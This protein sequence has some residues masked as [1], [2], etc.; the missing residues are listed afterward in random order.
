[1]TFETPTTTNDS[2]KAAN[3]D[4][5]PS[6]IEKKWRQYWEERGVYRVEEDPTKP[7]YYVLDMF[8]YPSGAGLHVG[9]PLGYVASDIFARY[10]RLKGFNVLHP[11]GY[12]A[13]GLPAEQYAIE[14]GIHPETTTRINTQRY[15]Q[16]LDNLGFSYDWSRQ[17]STNDPAYY[18]WT[19]EIFI[20]LYT[21]Y[22]DTAADKARPIADL[23]VAFEKGGN[24]HVQAHTTQEETFS[25]E[26]W[27]AFSPVEREHILMNYRLAYRKVGFVNWC[28]ALGTVLA[29]DE[30]KEGLSERGGHPVVKKPMLQWALRITAYADRLLAGLDEVQ[31]PDAI[32]TQQRN[33]IGKSQGAEVVF[34]VDGYEGEG[35]EVFTTRPDTIYGCTFLVLAPEHSLVCKITSAEQKQAVADYLQYTNARSERERM[36]EVKNVTG[37]FTGAYARHP[38][39]GALVPIWISEYVLAGYGTGAIMAVPAEDERDNRFARHFSLPIVPVLDK[40]AYPNA[41]IGDKV[42]TYV[43]SPLW[44]GL[45]VSEGIEKALQTLETRKLGTRKVNFKFHDANFSRQRYWGEPFPIKYDKDGIGH[46]ETTLPLTLPTLD[47]FHPTPDGQSPLARVT[48][49]VNTPDGFVRETDTMPGYAGSS[50]YFLRY[51]SPHHADAP[52]SAEA[53]SYWQEVDLY[54]GGSEHAVGHL[55]YARFFHK[56]LYD[57][58]KVPTQEPFRRLVNQGMIQGIVE[59]VYMLKEKRNGRAVFVSADR[60]EEFGGEAATVQIP[61]YIKFVSDYGSPDS[62]LD[63][64]GIEQFKEWRSDYADAHFE[65]NAYSHLVTRSEVGKMSKRYHNVVNPDDV[66]AQYGTDCFRMYEMFLGPL[67]DAKPWNTKG[68]DGVHRFLRRL[69]SLFFDKGECVVTDEAPNKDELRTLH[70]CIKRINQDLENL[71]LNTCVS[72]FMIAVNELK[73]QN[74]H[75]RAIL[76]PLTLLLAPF[77]PFMAEEFWQVALGETGSVHASSEFPTH[78]E[79]FLQV[80]T[81]TYPVCTNGKLRFT[82]DFAAAATTADIEQVVRAHERTA[83]LLD[84]KQLLKVVVVPGR[85]INLVVGNK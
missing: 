33:W 40:S 82:L 11:M 28:E 41:E 73:E 66:I 81:V 7:K 84:G 39:T 12:D 46:L 13:F 50:W 71:S 1:M 51:M 5:A 60:L 79:Q 52:F 83:A 2:K 10:K 29:N 23:V 68:I 36:T 62:Y 61:V 53:V 25:A 8:P 3:M 76:R 37:A 56:F 80:D 67:E 19:Q 64:R 26:Q 14:T 74:C 58:G 78:D 24:A 9:H 45:T 49:W 59:Q 21:H 15:R 20:Q 75:K 6:Q 63:L 54:V 22:Y 18:R 30:V 32:K 69:W 85:M 65:L 35:I 4:Y 55:L 27:A 31:F 16:Q 38:L 34:A 17:V 44:D 42:G 57:L 48:D 43:N 77:A 70:T 47:D 72:G